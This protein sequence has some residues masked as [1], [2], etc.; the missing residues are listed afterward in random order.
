MLGEEVYMPMV[1]F[2]PY[3]SQY[4]NIIIYYVIRV[5]YVL[6]LDTSCVLVCC[7][8]ARRLLFIVRLRFVKPA[9]LLNSTKIR[10]LSYPALVDILYDDDDDDDGSPRK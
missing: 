1:V 6:S 4:Y 9:K 7:K 5:Y 10:F 2:N 8:S 3:R